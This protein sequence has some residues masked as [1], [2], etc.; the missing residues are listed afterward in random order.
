LANRQIEAGITAELGGVIYRLSDKHKI[1]LE[2]IAKQVYLTQ[3][4]RRL[5]DP[6]SLLYKEDLLRLV[7]LFEKELGLTATEQQP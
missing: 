3:A 4:Y 2:D 5:A 1:P 7:K 6:S